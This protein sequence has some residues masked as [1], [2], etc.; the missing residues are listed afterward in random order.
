M[1]VNGKELLKKAKINKEAIFQFNINNFEWT[2]WI[3]EKC[4]ELNKPVILGVSEK[5]VNYMGGCNTVVSVVNNLIN[6]LNINIDVSLH[7]DHGKTVES[8]KKAIDAGFTSVMID[9]STKEFY[10]NIIETKEVVE[11]AK[12]KDVLVEAELGAMGILQNKQLNI[13]NKTNILD[14]IKF[15]KETKIDLLAP[16]VGTVHGIYKGKLDIDY[17]L[18]KEISK[19]VDIPLVL[20]GGSGLSNDILKKCIDSGITKININSDLQYVWSMGIRNYLKDNTDIID[21]RKIISS[22]E[23]LLKDEIEH[24]MMINN[25]I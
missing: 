8:C 19:N 22:G 14:C 21:P 16:S 6:D 7:L 3:L 9:L 4:N 11:Y 23:K 20:H 13:G 15:V 24:K 18:I 1:L 25:K 2:K 12:N 17:K 10:D 5:S